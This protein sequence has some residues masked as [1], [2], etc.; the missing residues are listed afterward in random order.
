[1]GLQDLHTEEPAQ[2]RSKVTH[3]Q[4][5][6]SR[7]EESVD[8]TPIIYE[9]IDDDDDEPVAAPT[10]SSP[11]AFNPFSAFCFKESKDSPSST[12]PP[13]RSSTWTKTLGDVKKRLAGNDRD[14][15]WRPL[16]LEKK[17]VSKPEALANRPLLKPPATA[18]SSKKESCEPAD[19]D[20]MAEYEK[21]LVQMKWQSILRV[22]KG[23][24]DLDEETKK[25]C[26]VAAVILSSRT[27]EIMVKQA[28]EKLSVRTYYV[29]SHRI[30]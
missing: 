10:A 21:R 15:P 11:K 29:F 20:K 1:M 14:H 13:P 8:E 7:Q 30:N 27:Q 23:Y 4:E 26:L 18:P 17:M 12:D 9:T 5:I 25:F 28:L 22:V 6:I 24:M 2:K 3:G 19:F 16:Q